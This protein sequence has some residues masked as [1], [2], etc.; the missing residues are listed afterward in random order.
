MKVRV[1]NGD[2]LSWT[3]SYIVFFII[4]YK[5]IKLLKTKHRKFTFFKKKKMIQETKKVIARLKHSKVHRKR[6]AQLTNQ[7][8]E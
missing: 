8:K 1:E 5:S 6:S 4:R 3:K 7:Y 2:F